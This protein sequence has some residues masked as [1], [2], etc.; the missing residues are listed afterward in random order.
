MVITVYDKIFEALKAYNDTLEQNYGNAIVGSSSINTTY[1][2]TV[3]E[4]IRND[5]LRRT[6]I[7]LLD[8][9]DNLGYEV[10]IYAKQK[11]K[12]DKKTIA[13]EIAKLLDDFLTN[14]I[15]L[16]LLS[17][18]PVPNLNDSSIYRINLRYSALY[19]ENRAKIL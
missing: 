5:P 18:N 1:P 8:R 16:K 12:I 11:G 7:K 19:Y 17:M 9:V 10:E 4:E 6:N 15:G 3:F 2:Q 14:V 13:R